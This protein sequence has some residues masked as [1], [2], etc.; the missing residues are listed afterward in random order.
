APKFRL[1]LRSISGDGSRAARTGTA[2]IFLGFLVY[3]VVL[4]PAGIATLIG[5][6]V[7]FSPPTVVSSVG[8]T[9]GTFLCAGARI[10]ISFSCS[11]PF[12]FKQRRLTITWAEMERIECVSRDDGSIGVLYIYSGT[13]R[14]E[15]G[16][17]AV[18]DLRGVHEV[19]LA[20]APR[21]AARPCQ[22]G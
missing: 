16:N 20:H 22:T 18:R 19:I 1:F 5:V 6:G 7:A 2:H 8:V 15:I 10:P 4:A 3:A 14:I 21:S 13:R 12:S 11:S 17:F 9:G